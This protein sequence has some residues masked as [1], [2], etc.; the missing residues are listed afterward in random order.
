[1]REGVLVEAGP[2]RPPDPEPVG[3]PGAEERTPWYRRPSARG[4]ALAF[5]LYL[6]VAVFVWWHVWSNHPTSVSACAC[7]DPGLVTWFL[8]WPAYAISH[9]LNPFFSSFMYHPYGIDLLSNAASPLFGILLAPV[10]WLFGPLAT[11]NLSL[12]IAPA[13]SGLTMFWLVRRWTRWTLAA[14]AAGLFYG[15]S[16]F[17]VVSLASGHLM[18]ASLMFLPLFVLVLEEL[19][20]RQRRSPVRTGVALGV[21]TFLQFFASTEVL[22]ITVICAASGCALLL[23]FGAIRARDALRRRTRHAL[24][25]LAVAAGVAVVG[26]AYPAW[27]ALDGPAHI[28]GQIWQGVSLSGQGTNVRALLG[29]QPLSAAGRGLAIAGGY[30]GPNLPGASSLGIGALAVIVV[31]L[32]LF[33]RERALWFF[34][35]LGLVSVVFAFGDTGSHLAPWRLLD[36]SSVLRNVIPLRFLAVTLMCVAVMAGIVIDRVHSWLRS[37]VHPRT[38][39]AGIT[40]VVG[41][42]LVAAAVVVPFG[43]AEAGALPLTLTKV[44]MP[45]WFRTR[46]TTLPAGSVVEYFPRP[47]PGANGRIL[48]WQAIDGMSF[49]TAQGSGP[50]NSH[51]PAIPYSQ[52]LFEQAPLPP[53]PTSV[54]ALR[55][56][57][58]QF[59]V[60]LGVLVPAVPLRRSPT[61]YDENLTGILTEALGRAPVVQ[62]GSLVWA[63]DPPAPQLDPGP[64][65]FAACTAFG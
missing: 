23:L 12:T 62:A 50:E 1:M 56:A 22:A 52:G 65:A 55:H 49:A 37:T 27:F 64:A 42:L 40:A 46:A 59:G 10:T 17:M 19:L 5:L 26:L 33:R 2:A 11:F 25:G 32:L 58:G 48:A 3:T 29:L 28:A 57:L 44:R 41:A 30:V 43:A 60:T 14:L 53:T 61:P 9:G 18:T 54:G 38:S 4:S 47:G 15:F 20:L 45:T 7:G 16:P 63:V 35:A 31:G 21:L 13:L 34:G 6:A 36:R 39:A 51:L 8:A 24:V